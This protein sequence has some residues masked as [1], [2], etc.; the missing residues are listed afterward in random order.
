MANELWTAREKLS[1]QGKRT[2][3]DTNVSKPESEPAPVKDIDNDLDTN[4]SN[5]VPIASKWTGD[6]ES[7]TPEKYIESFKL[8]K[9][10]EHTY[11]DVRGN[12]RR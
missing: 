6:Q 2:D 12:G 1:A 5:I 10:Q 3:L 9:V 11:I 7:Y 4:V 8:L